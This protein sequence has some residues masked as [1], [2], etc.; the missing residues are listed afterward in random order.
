MKVVSTVA[1]IDALEHNTTRG[2]VLTM[3]ALHD[4]H[5]A[6]MQECRRRIGTDGTLIVSIFVNPTQFSDP[7]D[8][9]KYPRT[10]EADLKIC[11]AAGVD[12][13]FAPTVD[14]I[15]PPNAVIEK[16]SAGPLGEILEGASRKGHFDGVATVVH[17]LLRI[18]QADVTCFGQ[19]DFQQIAV[20]RQMLRETG[21]DCELVEVETV[22]DSDGVAL[23][24]RNR[25]LSPAD[26]HKAVAIPQAIFAVA[27]ALEQ[28]RNL[29][30]ALDIGMEI[31][32]K[33]PE[34]VVDYLTVRSMQLDKPPMNGS[35]RILIAAHLGG[36]RLL[37]NCAATIVSGS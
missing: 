21:L 30:E 26:R 2:V 22:R 24:S 3:G 11:E 31:L 14:E 29:E 12:V 27:Q 8:L 36:V 10:L 4:G 37:D 15:Y 1:E 34:I 7:S 16:I 6:L 13:V 18:L 20:V 23:S 5:V 9:E 19:K 32:K 25:R 35:A 17:R 33:V 28:G